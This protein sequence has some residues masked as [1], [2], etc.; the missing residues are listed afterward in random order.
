MSDTVKS[1]KAIGKTVTLKDG[2]TG[3]IISTL[4]TIGK[5]GTVLI[6]YTVEKDNNTVEVG[7]DEVISIK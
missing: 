2:T 4:N 6:G 1:I 7:L 5:N 3:K